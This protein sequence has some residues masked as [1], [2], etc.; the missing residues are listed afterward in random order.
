M[1]NA[2][3]PQAGRRAAMISLAVVASATALV[4]TAS[5]AAA[6]PTGCFTTTI[7]SRNAESRCPGGTGEHRVIMRQRH[8]DPNVGEVDC[9]GPWVPVGSVSHVL[10]GV[11]QVVS[12]RLETR[13]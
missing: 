7:D 1:K 10:C 6:T 4:G 12:V 13:G 2:H 8:F 9:V 5:S 11:H 3:M